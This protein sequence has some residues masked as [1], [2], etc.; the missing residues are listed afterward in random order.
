MKIKNIDYE[1]IIL[2][3]AIFAVSMFRIYP[4]IYRIA[5]CVQKGTFGKAVL[6]DLNEI[7]IIKNKEKISLNKIE[8]LEIKNFNQINIKNVNFKYEDN[9]DLTLKNLNLKLIKG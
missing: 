4:S 9:L 7:F 1:I 2:N 8:Q 5:A 6:E 3:L